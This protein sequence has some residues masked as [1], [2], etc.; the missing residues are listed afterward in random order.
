ML[1]AAQIGHYQ[2]RGYVIP[3]YCLPGEAA[4]RFRTGLSWG[5]GATQTV[6]GSVGGARGKRTTSSPAFSPTRVRS[7]E[8]AEIRV[9]SA[10]ANSNH[11][12]GPSKRGRGRR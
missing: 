10:G 2:D 3:R 5:N 4:T 7:G 1:T 12:V 9:H 6:W 8:G 11:P